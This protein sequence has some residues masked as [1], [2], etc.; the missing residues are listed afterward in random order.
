MSFSAR[1]KEELS[2]QLSKARHCQIAE[3]AAILSLCGKIHIDEEDHFSIRIHT[4]NVAVARKYFTLLKNT[5]NIKADNTIRRN[6]FLKKCRSYTL[7]VCDH[8]NASG[9]WRRSEVMRRKCRGKLGGAESGDSECVLQEGIY[10]GRFSGSR[11]LKRSG[12]I[13]SF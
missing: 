9:C 8:E 2:H 6:A 1:V 5:F 12:E 11:I 4:E 10:P 3:L 7:L 13:L